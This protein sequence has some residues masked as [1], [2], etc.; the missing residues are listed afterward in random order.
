[1]LAHGELIGM[2]SEE[3]RVILRIDPENSKRTLLFSVET[4]KL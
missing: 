3:K 1:M 4:K 2:L